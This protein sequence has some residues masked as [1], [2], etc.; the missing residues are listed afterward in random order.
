MSKSNIIVLGPSGVGKSTL[1]NA[2]AGDRLDS[3]LSSIRPYSGTS[4]IEVHDCVEY[5]IQL[6][7]TVG[8]EP[9]AAKQKEA[10]R[11]VQKWTKEG[12]KKKSDAKSLDLVW[13]CVDG[14]SRRIFSSYIENFVKAVK[15]WKD[16]P[17]IVVITKSYSELERQENI[18]QIRSE[19]EK[20]EKQV[21]LKEIIPV[22][23]LPYNINDSVI[24]D[25]FGLQELMECTLK[26]LPEG[27]ENRVAIQLHYSLGRK[28]LWAR[29][30]TLASMAAAVGVGLTK[31]KFPAATILEPIEKKMIDQI[32]SQYEV[33]DDDRV[34]AIKDKLIN[35]G[36]VGIIAKKAAQ[37][38]RNV[39]PIRVKGIRIDVARVANAI[40][41]GSIVAGIGESSRY[42]FEKL[43]LKDESADSLDWIDK[44]LEEEMSNKI[45]E[46]IKKILANLKIESKKDITPAAIL[47]SIKN[48]FFPDENGAETKNEITN[49]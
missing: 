18:E 37:L 31:V 15:I 26:N 46:N 44:F 32:A 48:T 33:A 24:V 47:S 13:F 10:V 21:N 30:T 17:V 5:D 25:S 38:L 9:S 41:A 35:S 42:V 7:D 49:N 27:K 8:F 2:V 34:K 19:F 22:V 16:I 3:S 11:M 45:I 1:I 39:P 36:T 20:Y 40:V 6:V 28:R 4:E 29:G 43:Y 12:V 14:T 23:A